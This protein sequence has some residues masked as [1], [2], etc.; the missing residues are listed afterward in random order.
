MVEVHAP[1]ND[2]WTCGNSNPP[3]GILGTCILHHPQNPCPDAGGH[4]P[5]KE[6]QRDWCQWGTNY[7]DYTGC[8][9][10]CATRRSCRTTAFRSRHGKG[11][12]PFRF[13]TPWRR[14]GRLSLPAPRPKGRSGG[15]EVLL[16]PDSPRSRRRQANHP[17]EKTGTREA[18]SELALTPIPSSSA[19]KRSR[20][21]SVMVPRASGREAVGREAPGGVRPPRAAPLLA[22]WGGFRS[23]GGAGTPLAMGG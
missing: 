23:A 22:E 21:A 12:G 1:A 17:R 15:G 3:E 11:F 20:T 2:T 16:H 14:W 10:C 5:S 18:S 6:Q 7:Q 4:H 19:P 8:G 9:C 13:E